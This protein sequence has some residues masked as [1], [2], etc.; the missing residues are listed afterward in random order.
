M[1]NNDRILKINDKQCLRINRKEGF[2]HVLY[3]ENS[4]IRWVCYTNITHKKLKVIDSE[5]R[6]Y[7][8]I[9]G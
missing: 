4:S 8:D 5:K 6:S 2:L 1:S 7:I 3:L 9:I